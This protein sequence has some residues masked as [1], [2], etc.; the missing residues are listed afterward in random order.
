MENVILTVY[1]LLFC[2]LEFDLFKTKVK[3]ITKSI[4]RSKGTNV[5]KHSQKLFVTMKI[6]NSC[7]AVTKIP[8]K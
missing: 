3:T 2:Y 4:I 8:S 5:E 1:L 7:S 6:S